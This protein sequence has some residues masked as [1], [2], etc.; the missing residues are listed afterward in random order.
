MKRVNDRPQVQKVLQLEGL[1]EYV[2]E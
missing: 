1:T 2:P